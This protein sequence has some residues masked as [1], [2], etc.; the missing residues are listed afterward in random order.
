MKTKLIASMCIIFPIFL[1]AQNHFPFI[2]S[3][4]TWADIT[5]FDNIVSPV[6]IW[7]DYYK[8][9]QD[10]LIQGKFYHSLFSCHKDPSMTNWTLENDLYR[11]DSNKVYRYNW[12]GNED[13]M[14]NFNLLEGDSVFIPDYAVEF[15]SAD[16]NALIFTKRLSI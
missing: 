9:G 2:E 3:G 5:I 11:E 15:T 7:T 12:I 10:T 8:F 14:Y 6:V 1:S 13:L 4:K 16:P